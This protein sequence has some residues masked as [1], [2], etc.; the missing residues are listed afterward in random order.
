[1]ASLFNVSKFQPAYSEM[2]HMKN[3]YLAI[4]L[5]SIIFESAFPASAQ[6]AFDKFK[7]ADV[8]NK[9]DLKLPPTNAFEFLQNIRYGIDAELFLEDSFFEPEN[10]L[11]FTNAKSVKGL[12]ANQNWLMIRQANIEGVQRSIEATRENTAGDKM[13]RLAI[14]FFSPEIN[15]DY[16]IK[17]F[18]PITKTIDPYKNTDARHPIPLSA[19]TH[20]LGNM[21]ICHSFIS[22]Q[23]NTEICSLTSGSGQVSQFNVIQTKGN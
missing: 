12:G 3:L 15:V 13:G 18:G 22:K 2:S 6:S 4:F 14:S 19:K 11:L 23:V 17:I 20:P 7:S 1:M 8:I 16:I 10:I 5:I 21:E 9:N